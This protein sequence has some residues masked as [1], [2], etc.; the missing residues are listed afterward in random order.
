MMINKKSMHFWVLI[1]CFCIITCKEVKLEPLLT[2]N[3]VDSKHF[4]ISKVIDSIAAYISPRTL[5]PITTKWKFTNEDSIKVHNEMVEFVSKSRI[6]AIDTSLKVFIPEYEISEK[7]FS[8][9]NYSA[10]TKA[11]DSSE[12]I[13]VDI[14]KIKLNQVNNSFYFDSITYL[15]PSKHIRKSRRGTYIDIDYRF[16]FSCIVYN[17]EKTIAVVRCI[18]RYE[19]RYP[20]GAIF[21]LDKN[22]EDW[23]V[24]KAHFFIG[25]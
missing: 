20:N 8:T 2:Q 19:D 7:M 18:Y 17:K 4:V 9:D 6:I 16:N 13:S 10:I 24:S 3:K 25:Y 22:D 15:N 23:L 1:F 14:N 21:L 12:T 11:Y 5:S